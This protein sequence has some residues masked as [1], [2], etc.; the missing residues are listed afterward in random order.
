M[1]NPFKKT[2]TTYELRIFNFLSSIRLFK[3]LTFKEMSYFLPYMHERHYQKDEVVFFRDDPS[4]AL[5]LLKR[6]EVMLNIDVNDSF[7]TLTSVK[8][9]AVLGES[10]LLEKNKRQLNAFVVSDTAQFYVIPQ[11][12]IFSIFENHERVKSKML[13]ELATIYS[14]YNA[15]LFR[16]YRA[17]F[18]FFHLSQ[19]YSRDRK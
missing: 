18:G 5:Y 10:C 12:N 3:S 9:G 19:I 1:I 16:A 13:K 8:G 11:D 15:N 17:S 14:E 4:H 7:E 2:Y 6:G